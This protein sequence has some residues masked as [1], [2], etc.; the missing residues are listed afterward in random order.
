MDKIS[1][2]NSTICNNYT[3]RMSDRPIRSK[4]ICIWICRVTHMHTRQFSCFC[5]YVCALSIG[6]CI[7]E[8]A[9]TCAHV[10]FC[11]HV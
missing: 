9:H 5:T 10:Q 4:Q 6:T 2:K 3:P 1:L 7:C 11:S 8:H